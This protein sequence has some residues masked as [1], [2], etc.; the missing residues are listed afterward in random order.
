MGNSDILLHPLQP[1]SYGDQS[2]SVTHV[3]YDSWHAGQQHDPTSAS[4]LS[5]LGYCPWLGIVH[6]GFPPL[7][8]LFHPVISTLSSRYK[9]EL[10]IAIERESSLER[11]R[12]QLEVDWQRRCE[13]TEREVYMKHEELVAGLTKQRDQVWISFIHVNEFSCVII[14]FVCWQWKDLI[15]YHEENDNYIFS[16]SEIHGYRIQYFHSHSIHSKTF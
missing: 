7:L 1:T 6:Y 15:G 11:S 3:R 8:S 14:L 9:K 5:W 10:T 16:L 4:P 12:A 13:D 2:Y